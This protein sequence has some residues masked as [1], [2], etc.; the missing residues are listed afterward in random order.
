MQKKNFFLQKKSKKLL[1]RWSNKLFVP[2]N[3][4]KLIAEA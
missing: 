1:K 2:D 3:L 4:L